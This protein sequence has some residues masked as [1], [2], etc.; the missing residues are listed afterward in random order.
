MTDSGE[1]RAAMNCERCYRIAGRIISQC[2]GDERKN[3]RI[4][5]LDE[6]A[7]LWEARNEAMQALEY[8]ISQTDS[9]NDRRI[10]FLGDMLYACRTCNYSRA[11]ISE[12]FFPK[13]ETSAP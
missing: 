8:G 2:K 4:R 1:N 13:Q 6:D 9:K 10:N 11:Q 5:K 12:F 3:E 7:S